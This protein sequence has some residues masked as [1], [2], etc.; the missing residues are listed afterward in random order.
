MR[1]RAPAAPCRWRF[2]G[3]TSNAPPY[4]E[5]HAFRSAF[6]FDILTHT[7]REKAQRSVLKALV[8]GQVMNHWVVLEQCGPDTQLTIVAILD[9]GGA[10]P[11]SL[12]S[13]AIGEMGAFFVNL[14]EFV[15]ADGNQ[16]RIRKVVE[17]DREAN[18]VDAKGDNSS[19][20]KIAVE[21]AAKRSDDILNNSW[22]TSTAISGGVAMMSRKPLPGAPIDPVRCIGYIRNINAD[23]LKCVMMD[24]GIKKSLSELTPSPMLLFDRMETHHVQLP[25]VDLKEYVRTTPVAVAKEERKQEAPVGLL[26]VDSDAESSLASLGLNGTCKL[27]LRFVF[28]LLWW[29]TFCV[30]QGC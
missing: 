27:R 18:Q 5:C 29:L 17:A 19:M 12:I 4:I 15:H 10:I 8:L 25:R 16:D 22:G 1:N 2:L 26:A 14:Q 30:G 23:V 6:R 11:P 24:P 20:A 21:S 3:E 9:M 28:A 7:Q 13:M